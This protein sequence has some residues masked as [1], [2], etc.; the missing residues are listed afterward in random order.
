MRMHKKRDDY[1]EYFFHVTTKLANTPSKQ[2]YRI[3]TFINGLYKITTE[4]IKLVLD[5]EQF[6]VI[7]DLI[8]FTPNVQ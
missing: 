4:T 8:V 1:R 2:S 7:S 6:G 3:D 5:V